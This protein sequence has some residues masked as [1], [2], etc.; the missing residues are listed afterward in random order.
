MYIKLWKHHIT[1]LYYSIR[2]DNL[3]FKF[4]VGRKWYNFDMFEIIPWE[5]DNSKGL[6]DFCV[7][8]LK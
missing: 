3:E 6:K 8:V 4:D 2:V 5:S 1:E 7:S